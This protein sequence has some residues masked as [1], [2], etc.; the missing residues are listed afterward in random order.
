[1]ALFNT[2]FAI[3]LPDNNIVPTLSF[4][5]F[6]DLVNHRAV[7]W[8]GIERRLGEKYL[9]LAK[10]LDDTVS[11]VFLNKIHQHRGNK[12]TGAK[13]ILIVPDIWG[14][15]G[16]RD[17][18]NLAEVLLQESGFSVFIAVSAHPLTTPDN[19]AE[20][21][22][23]VCGSSAFPVVDTCF[24]SN[25][26]IG[27]GEFNFLGDIDFTFSRSARKFFFLKMKKNSKSNF[28]GMFLKPSLFDF[29]TY[30]G[31]SSRKTGSEVSDQFVLVSLSKS[32]KPLLD[33]LPA[34]GIFSKT[35]P[36]PDGV[37][38]FF[39][40]V[41]LYSPE[42]LVT[43]D[44][45]FSILSSGQ[46]GSYDPLHQNAVCDAATLVDRCVPEGSV[47]ILKIARLDALK[48]PKHRS[49]IFSILD[50]L[51]LIVEVFP[52]SRYYYKIRLGPK[53][54]DEVLVSA[55]VNFNR[56]MSRET[57]PLFHSLFC[58]NDTIHSL[59]YRAPPKEKPLR[60][61][62][63]KKASPSA[64]VLEDPPFLLTLSMVESWL[65]FKGVFSA[66]PP[67]WGISPLGSSCVVVEFFPDGDYDHSLFCD[68]FLEGEKFKVLFFTRLPF[69]YRLVAQ[70]KGVPLPVLP[71]AP[72]KPPALP[73]S[74]L[75]II[76]NVLKENFPESKSDFSLP[77]S[78]SVA[79]SSFSVGP[80]GE[81]RSVGG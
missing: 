17:A 56:Q 66:R 7:T 27:L 14:N 28:S 41:Q 5:D 1:M 68:F 11:G 75:L 42:I 39:S 24:F 67:R 64:L 26:L 51:H 45:V 23:H 53:T 80:H 79:S 43:K 38:P 54:T 36:D 65:S 15:L 48:E 71:S 59:L 77:E 34:A 19:A 72:S 20:I 9:E 12:N 73:K 13:S 78:K 60:D 47:R 4:K 30:R 8:A 58:G 81:R 61:Y 35:I 55:L 33:K 2:L 29:S 74:L 10:N 18:F 57:G 3:G 22:P 40:G 49:G 37:S 63:I 32:Q 25:T 70:D 62:F 21:N 16:L 31:P 76:E 52:L 50:Q 46:P 69:S 6:S 44:L